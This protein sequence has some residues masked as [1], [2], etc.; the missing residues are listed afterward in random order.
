MDSLD[1]KRRLVCKTSE[2][3]YGNWNG[4]AIILF[5]R[6]VRRHESYERYAEPESIS[7]EGSKRFFV[8]TNGLSIPCYRAS[9]APEEMF[10]AAR[11]KCRGHQHGHQMVV[12]EY[13]QALEDYA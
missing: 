8:S 12:P 7:K 2:T 4:T 5:L 10:V 11:R 6:A 1:I 9:V 3:A 13:V